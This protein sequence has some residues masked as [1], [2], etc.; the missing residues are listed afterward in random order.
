[1][2]IA[3]KLNMFQT[4]IE[5][6]IAGSS[7]NRAI[8][9]ERKYDGACLEIKKTAEASAEKRFKDECI[10][11]ELEMNKKIL[12][13][14]TQSKKN[15][16]EQRER[17]TDS[18]FEKVEARLDGFTKSQAYPEYLINKINEAKDGIISGN[19]GIGHDDLEIFLRQEDMCFADKIKNECALFVSAAAEDFA[20]GFLLYIKTKN[21]S[22][23]MTFKTKLAEARKNYQTVKVSG[24]NS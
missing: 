15:L 11:T 13:L 7:A 10:K 3:N 2:N 23:D 4:I 24:D 5:R 12:V 6:D 1:M 8:E 17:L 21:A 22:L 14:S 19:D 20:G 16:A 9:A 18:L